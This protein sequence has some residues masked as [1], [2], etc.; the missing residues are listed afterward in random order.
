MPGTAQPIETRKLR[1][2]EMRKNAG[3]VS[4]QENNFKTNCLKNPGR[5]CN[6]SIGF[7]I[8]TDTSTLLSLF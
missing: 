3:P 4:R 1:S 7:E 8:S 2:S 6:K 5:N